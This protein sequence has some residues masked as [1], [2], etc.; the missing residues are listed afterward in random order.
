MEMVLKA[1]L[2]TEEF[3]G[4]GER[5]GEGRCWKIMG[6]GGKYIGVGLDYCS[7]DLLGKSHSRQKGVGMAGFVCGGADGGSVHVG[8]V[9]EAGL[10]KG[11]NS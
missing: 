1:V 9:E 8:N 3:G 5:R 7:M 10:E 11:E 4:G 2:P 6:N